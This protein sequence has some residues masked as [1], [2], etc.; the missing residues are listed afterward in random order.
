M[1]IEAK[2]DDN[3]FYLLSNGNP[4]HFKKIEMTCSCGC[5][6]AKMTTDIIEADNKFRETVNL[7]VIIA[8]GV[9][10][11]V[12]NKK[13][14]GA[15]HSKHLPISCASDKN[16]LSLSDEDMFLKGIGI[17][18]AMGFYFR[19]SNI[20]GDTRVDENGNPDFLYWY[21][22]MEK[23]KNGIWQYSQYIYFNSPTECLDKYKA[24]KNI[25]LNIK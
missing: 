13:D 14:G 18:N 15:P 10:C 7:P 21:R 19:A 20:H 22:D 24:R 8:R 1:I 5:G 25:I 11:T 6:E 4:S 16:V 23:D 2:I 12:Q 9:S 3:G 17:Y